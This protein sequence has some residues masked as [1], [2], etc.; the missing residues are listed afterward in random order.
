MESHATSTTEVEW[1]GV[2]HQATIPLPPCHHI[3]TEMEWSAVCH[4]AIA[5]ILVEY[6]YWKRCGVDPWQYYYWSGVESHATALRI[7]EYYY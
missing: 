5:V 7:V 3:S 1:S 4:H 6:Y 2:C